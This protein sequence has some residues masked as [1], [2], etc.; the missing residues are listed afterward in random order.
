MAGLCL[1]FPVFKGQKNYI[2]YSIIFWALTMTGF[3]HFPLVCPGLAVITVSINHVNC[4][5]NCGSTPHCGPGA[6]YPATGNWN[7]IQLTLSDIHQYLLVTVW[8]G[9]TSQA[10]I[11]ITTSPIEALQMDNSLQNEKIPSH[12][13]EKCSVELWPDLVATAQPYQ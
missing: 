10:N 8:P 4:T 12:L 11:N 13:E 3:L 2:F 7:I 1:H 5:S 9:H 6:F